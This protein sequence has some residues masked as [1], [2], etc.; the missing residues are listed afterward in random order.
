MTS[1]LPSE[2]WDII[3]LPFDQYDLANL[4]RVNREW[5]AVFTP[6]LYFDINISNTR[7]ETAFLSPETKRALTR[8]CSYIRKFGTRS[9]NPEVLEVL[10]DLPTL[11]LTDINLGCRLIPDA[12]VGYL[13]E[14]FE[15]SP[16]LVSLQ[17][18]GIP[19][20]LTLRMAGSL[21]RAIARSLVCLRRLD[22]FQVGPVIMELSVL[23][24]FFETVSSELEYL[25]AKMSLWRLQDDPDPASV[26]AWPVEERK[27][28]PLLRTFKFETSLKGDWWNVS[29]EQPD[30]DKVSDYLPDVLVPFLQ[31]CPNLKCVDDDDG[32]ATPIQQLSW[33]QA[34]PA[35]QDCLKDLFGFRYRELIVDQSNVINRTIEN[36]DINPSVDEIL[37]STIA[38]PFFLDATSTEVYHLV[39]L[40][41]G[42]EPLP[43]SLAMIAIAAKNGLVDKIQV[44]HGAEFT[45]QDLKLLFQRGHHLQRLHCWQTLPCIS[46][47]DFLAGPLVCTNLV[48][49]EIQIT[50]VPRPDITTNYLGEPLVLDQVVHSAADLDRVRDTHREIYTRLATLVN[51]QVL[52][53]GIRTE[54]DRLF[55]KEE[56]DRKL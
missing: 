45:G 48:Q 25:A 38:Q 8:N 18:Y 19:M 14:I 22:I 29:T 52:A 23:K 43:L 9:Q 2:L 6:Y 42:S 40:D 16:R 41:K 33:I 21:L 36:E 24:E 15:R 17:I 35:I 46:V 5:N 26:M 1:L 47:S 53:L 7:Q 51:L 30:R 44:Q 4:S 10:K 31:G 37:E 3:T 13:I 49:L 12:A 11:Q 56:G 39:R 50:N 28:H 20:D 54:H 27:A 55:C 34:F 32:P